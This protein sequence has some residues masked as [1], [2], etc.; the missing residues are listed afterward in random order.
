MNES[1]EERLSFEQIVDAM[2]RESRQMWATH[3]SSSVRDLLENYLKS[4]Q[5][6]RREEALG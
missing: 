2:E 1:S 4:V 3:P 6:T 5:S